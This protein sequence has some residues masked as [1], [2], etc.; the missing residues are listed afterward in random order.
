[1]PD[2]LAVMGSIREYVQRDYHP[3]QYGNASVPT[4]LHYLTVSPGVQA[5]AAAQPR[6]R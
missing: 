5:R 6:V 3:S 2:M 4:A 1:M